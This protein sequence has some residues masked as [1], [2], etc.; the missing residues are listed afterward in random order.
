M[1]SINKFS[2]GIYKCFKIVDTSTGR[3]IQYAIKLGK[4]TEKQWLAAHDD[5]MRSLSHEDR[6][7]ISGKALKE[8][9]SEWML[10]PKDQKS[11][12][13]KSGMKL[14]SI[15]CSEHS[16]RKVTE[17]YLA[18]YCQPGMHTPTAIGN[19]RRNCRWAMKF[20]DFMKISSY[21]SLRHDI[22][23]K[24]PEWRTKA[25]GSKAAAD[26]V[27]TELRRIGDIIRH[28]VKYCGW[29]ERYLMDGVKVKP[30][31]ENTKAVKPFEIQEIK[32]ILAWL[33]NHASDSGNWHWHDM[34]LLAICTGMEAKALNAMKPDWFKTELGILRVFDKLISGVIDAKTQHRARDIPITPTMMKLHMRG[35]IHD[36]PYRQEGKKY[37]CLLGC[38]SRIL[39]K[40]ET[41]ANIKDVNWHRFR[42]TYATARLS[43]GWQLVRVSRMLGHSN[44]STTATH[45]AEY[46][47]S[48]SPAG[49][50]GMMK[51]YGDFMKWID[52][53]YFASINN[54][55]EKA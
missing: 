14:A 17:S 50:E 39:E 19:A 28:G 12:M 41:E 40:L 32:D 11:G 42:H 4:F 54:T 7:S 20:F 34:V 10:L 3:R 5:V 53:D 2:V 9:V 25:N 23:L 30:T 18:K 13:K 52:E 46:D 6:A 8:I 55:N 45:Y 36:R 21:S 1:A 27:N 24:Y 38:S 33:R 16:I 22:I 51:V 44:I 37:N 26:T 35:H 43:S 47:L 49:F 48:S 15:E 31:P 29:T